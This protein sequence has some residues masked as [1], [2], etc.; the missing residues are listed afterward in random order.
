MDGPYLSHRADTEEERHLARRALTTPQSLR[1]NAC[2]GNAVPET[3][4]NGSMRHEEY[5]AD[6]FCPRQRNKDGQYSNKRFKSSADGDDI[7]WESLRLTLPGRSML[8]D[9]LQ[10]D[11]DWH[12]A[13]MHARMN[14]TD[15]SPMA[16]GSPDSH[17]AK[18]W[19]DYD[20]IGGEYDD[21]P[22]PF[23]HNTALGT[24][25]R[26]FMG[27]ERLSVPM[28]GS[29]NVIRE[30]LETDT[31]QLRCDQLRRGETPLLNAICNPDATSE[32]V[33]LLVD[34]DILMGGNHSCSAIMRRDDNGLLP[35]DHL[36]IGVSRGHP[37][38]ALEMVKYIITVVPELVHPLKGISPLIRLLTQATSSTE[39]AASNQGERSLDGLVEEGR[40]K[41]VVNCVDFLLAANT[42]LVIVPSIMTKCTPLHLALRHEF[43]DSL[44]AVIFKYDQT[45]KQCKMRN[46]FG[47]LVSIATLMAS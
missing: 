41:R 25:C 30:L 4:G 15:C 10:R 16:L 33:K 14:P 47:D 13:L 35:L 32:L 27:G 29:I 12:E 11:G 3:Y 5:V 8:V 46:T 7:W 19:N 34:T 38:F 36:L 21:L 1:H 18:V 40:K 22:R 9:L 31:S 6:S 20:A 23:F 44:V 39:T 2:G 42:G 17:H 37:T 28:R 45:G 26:N 24:A 43:C